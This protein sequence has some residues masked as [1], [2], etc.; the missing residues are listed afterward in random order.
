[1]EAKFN[2]LSTNDKHKFIVNAIIND[3][4]FEKYHTKFKIDYIDYIDDKEEIKKLIEDKKIKQ[5]V[6]N[7]IDEL[8]EYERAV[9]KC[10]TNQSRYKDIVYDV[11]SAINSINQFCKTKYINNSTDDEHIFHKVIRMYENT[12]DTVGEYGGEREGDQDQTLNSTITILLTNPELDEKVKESDE[13]K[14]YY[15]RYLKFKEN[16]LDIDDYD[17]E[18]YYSD[19]N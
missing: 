6:K 17:Y 14:G 5:K 10:C 3:K 15:K 12:Y 7:F 19:D 1:M 4:F 2:K 11:Y 13:Y 18:G 8:W 16:E 9:D